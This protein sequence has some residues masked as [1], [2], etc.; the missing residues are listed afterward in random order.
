MN[1]FDTNQHS[2]VVFNHMRKKV[3]KI[4]EKFNFES[5]Q[6]LIHYLTGDD[7]LK[8]PRSYFRQPIITVGGR[9]KILG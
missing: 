3:S 2:A 8:W 6:I 5:A 9:Q 7:I 4:I 1:F